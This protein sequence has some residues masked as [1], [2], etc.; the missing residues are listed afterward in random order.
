MTMVYSH[1]VGSLEKFFKPLLSETSI[2]MH[3]QLANID[4]IFTTLGFMHKTL[5]PHLNIVSNYSFI[6]GE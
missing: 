4:T 5:L 6:T 2:L 3:F 1:E